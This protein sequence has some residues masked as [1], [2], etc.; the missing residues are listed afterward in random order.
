MPFTRRRWRA[1]LVALSILSLTGCLGQPT[2]G[3][4]GE[5][6]PRAEIASADSTGARGELTLCGI[7]DTGLFET[8]IAD[9]NSRNPGVRARYI[10]I[11]QD[12]DA[13]RAQAIQRLEGGSR[14]CDIYLTDVTWTSQWA[15]QGWLLDHTELVRQRAADLIPSTL[16]TVRYDD[17]YWAMPFFTNAGLLFHREDR[18]PPPTTWEQVFAHA[19]EDE[20]NRAEIQAKQYEGLTVNFLELLYS[21]GGSVLD[22]QGDVTI[23]SPQT[24]EVLRVM[25]R[26]LDDGAIDRASLTYNEDNARRAYES[27]AAGY[28][29]QWPSA[30]ELIAQTG[31]GPVT[32]VSRLPAFDER[33]RP[34]AVLGGWNLAIAATSDNVPAA[35][36]FTDYAT[37]ARTQEK[38]VLEHTQA[39]VFAAVYD[40][41]QVRAEIPFIGELKKSVLSARSRPKSPVYTQI[42]RAIYDNVYEVISGQTD[43]ESGVREMREDIETAQETF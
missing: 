17:R 36:A 18:V 28:L 13:A 21:A 2:A 24:R 27:G 37:S 10:E 42:S 38:M 25:A 5:R 9:F 8:L 30:H 12:T 43:V 14:E 3:Q 16:D 41:P 33:G 23:D 39:P 32:G 34:A 20:R 11:G 29:R 22:E 19:G 4:V 15:A 26:G 35:V 40:D 7:R 31:T 1:S 6:A